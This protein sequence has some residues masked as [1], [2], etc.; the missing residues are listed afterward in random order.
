[1]LRLI[2]LLVVILLVHVSRRLGIARYLRHRKLVIKEDSLSLKAK[3][4][5]NTVNK[6]LFLKNQV[7][8]GRLD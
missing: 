5:R 2:F 4:E 3:W 8:V 7:S 6:H 1:M